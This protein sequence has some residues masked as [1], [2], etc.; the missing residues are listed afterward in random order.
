MIMM[1]RDGGKNRDQIEF[2]SLDELVPEDHLVRKLENA[3]DWSFIYEMVADS[4]CEDNG[5]PSLDPV[6]LIK[7][8]VVQYM[9]GIRSMRQTIQ[10]IKVNNAY[11]WFL[12]LGLHD[13]VP[14][15][16]TFGKNYMR[17]FKDSDLFERIFQKILK[18]CTEAGLVDES[19]VFV[20]STHVKARANSKKY[21]D[22]VVEEQALWYE[23]ELR[24]EIDRDREAHG[25]KPLKDEPGEPQN[26][27]EEPKPPK[28]SGKGKPNPN[29][30]K[31]KKARQKKEKHIKQSTSDPESGWFRK[32]EHKNVF[33]YSVQ[34]ACDINGVVL[35][36]SVHPGNENDGKTFPGV[37]E[38]IEHLN[39]EV[40][41][42]D[43]AFKTPAIARKMKERGIALLSTY[44][45]PKT[46]DGFFPKHEYV[47]DEYFDCYLCPANEILSY[48]TTNRDGY[49]EYKSDPKICEHCPYLN[50]CTYS[51]AHVKVVTRHVWQDAVDEADENR[52]RYDL[53]DLYKYR[54]ETIERIFGLAKELHGFRYTQQFGKAQMEV[55]AALTYACLNLKK[56]AKKRWKNRPIP[57]LSHLILDFFSNFSNIYAANPLSASA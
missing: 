40:M 1:T 38:K 8:P 23:K 4:Y 43:T 44:S 27:D 21:E 9:F 46:K 55:K 14:H 37:Y 52:Y 45:R 53:K 42:G 39:I 5:R 11:R 35:G 3:I 19:V 2:T 33:A 54:K 28:D 31:K 50:Q 41:V 20:D 13:P 30:S 15:F 47:Y 57:S 7:L 24:E 10:E 51:Q 6:I 34:T 22:A 18:E 48:S 16:S 49:R 56:L 17:R 36:Y 25:K 29:T 12:G 26:D 32:G